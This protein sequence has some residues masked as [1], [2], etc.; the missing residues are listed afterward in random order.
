MEIFL[1]V[2]KLPFLGS[3]RSDSRVQKQL[4]LQ[5]GT[6]GYPHQILNEHG[7][8]DNAESVEMSKN[9][10]ADLCLVFACTVTKKGFDPKD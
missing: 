3:R 5:N 2:E 7:K 9:I 6:G 4:Y 8:V 1:H 10:F